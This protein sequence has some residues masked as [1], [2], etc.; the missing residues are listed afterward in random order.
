KEK[1]RARGPDNPAHYSMCCRGG[2]VALP[3][4]YFDFPPV[5]RLL[6][7]LLT[8]DHATHIRSYNNALSFTSLGTP[9][10]ASV[11][12]HCF[13]IQGQLVHKLGTILPPAEGEYSFAQIYIMGPEIED[14]ARHRVK[15]SGV[16]I[17]PVIMKQLIDFLDQ[18]NP[19]AKQFRSAYDIMKQHKTIA[20]QL[21]SIQPTPEQ[22]AGHDI[23]TYARPSAT[24][25]AMIVDDGV[26]IG[27]GDRDIIVHS[28]DEMWHRVSDLHTGYLP[29]RYPLLF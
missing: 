17:D 1:V 14:E 12:G 16:K 19:Y 15:M 10:D 25:V 23:R 22:A 20:I 6:Y 7:D 29:L 8:K 4:H 11:I 3:Q 21:K 28:T 24:E 2:Q 5:P 9:M 26:E 18:H 27:R 13:K